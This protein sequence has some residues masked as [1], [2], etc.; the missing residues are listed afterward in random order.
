MTTKDLPR[1]LTIAGFDGS[2]G[3]GIQADLKTFSALGCY[4]LTVLTAMPVQNTT[5][6][7]AIYDI[8]TQCVKDQLE[9]TFDDSRI[10]AIKIGMLQRQD[11]IETVSDAL[12][13]S[14]S[15]NIVVDPVM[16]AK[17][18]H[19]LL[20]PNA[21]EAMKTQLFPLAT[22]ITPNLLEA[23]ELLG[24]TI[25]DKEQMEQAAI[26]LL[27]MGPK[28]VIVKGGHLI[29]NCDDCLC[30]GSSPHD[31]FW[32]PQTRIDTQNTHGTGCTFSAA[33]TAYLARGYSICDAVKL[34]KQYLT[35]AIAAGANLKIGK[36]KGPVHHF[37]QLW[38]FLSIS[39]SKESL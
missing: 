11:I 6:V 16:V 20:D 12:L 24:R 4:G 9:A 17:S 31:I 35:N 5:G 34:A 22:L 13:K 39:Q 25:A 10:D 36:G 27:S 30:I 37:H 1:T 18:G 26:E 38:E 8:P 33:I 28:A 2:G 15:T 23:S 29:G 14:K 3:A 19:L 32:F 7:K 21:I